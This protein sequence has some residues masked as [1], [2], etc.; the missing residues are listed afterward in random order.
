VG[1]G[2]GH[3]KATADQAGVPDL[4]V[5]RGRDEAGDGLAGR[6]ADQRDA[7]VG[8]RVDGLEVPRR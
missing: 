4:A 8:D 7:V 3:Q 1:E 6:G 2:P 5:E